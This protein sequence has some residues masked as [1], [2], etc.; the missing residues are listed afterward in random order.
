MIDD[1]HHYDEHKKSNTIITVKKREK[2][3]GFVNKTH[4]EE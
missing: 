4:Y 1:L 2:S 3:R